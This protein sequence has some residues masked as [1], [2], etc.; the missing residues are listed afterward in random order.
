MQTILVNELRQRYGDFEAVGGISFEVGEG[1]LFALLGT[2]GAGKTTTLETLEGF[3]NAGSGTVRVLGHDPY[4]ER[5]ALRPQLG[6]MLQE[7]GFFADL[8]VAE[9]VDQWRRFTP[10]PRERDEVLG[11]VGLPQQTEVRT[12]QLSGGQKRRLDLALALLGRPRVLFLDEPTTGMDPEAR[13]A[14][15]KIV[16]EL[17]ADGTTVLLT[18]HY[19]EE[20]EQL[21]DRLAIMHRG[22][23]EVAGTVADV[24]AG[25]GDRITFRVPDRVPVSDLPTLCG[26][27][28]DIAVESGRAVAGYRVQGLQ[29]SLY[30][31]LRWA[32]HHRLEL[33]GLQARSASLEDVFLHTAAATPEG[34]VR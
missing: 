2:N 18:T 27:V 16:R 28:A 10:S 31:L 5:R 3:R 12:R 8:T 6:I 13:H 34:A 7:A 24:V 26:A 4:R 17:V 9:T 20:A 21:A 1:E 19:L 29:A 30:E 32:E 15:W 11:M 33:D 23:I 14:T 22:R 25:Q